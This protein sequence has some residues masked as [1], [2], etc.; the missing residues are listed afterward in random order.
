MK[1]IKTYSDLVKIPDFLDR[2]KFLRLGGL[3]GEETFG[4]ERYLSQKF[5]KSR[6]WELVRRD[7]LIRD[8]GCNM[9]HPSYPISG[10]ILVHHINPINPKDLLDRE[11][12]IY[13]PENLVCVSLEVHRA[14][15][16]GDESLIPRDPVQRYPGDT[17]LW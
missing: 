8:N 9:A 14:I 15:H 17:K 16:Y 5:Y 10:K 4:Y 13:D 11:F 7:I 6:E 2:Y 3:I 1:W 12:V